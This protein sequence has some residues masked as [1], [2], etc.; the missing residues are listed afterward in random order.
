MAEVKLEQMKPLENSN[1]NR[2]KSGEI[3]KEIK[4]P[5]PKEEQELHI[6]K[7]IAKGTMK[8][9][10]IGTRL[11]EIFV[12]EDIKNVGQYI[13]TEVF[14]PTIKNT[15][16]DIVQNGVS[17]LIF[18]E[19]SSKNDRRRNGQYVS[20]GSY[21]SNT[22]SNSYRGSNRRDSERDRLDNKGDII[23][24]NR[25]DAQA[26][27]SH[28]CDALDIYRSVTVAN[29]YEAADVPSNYQDRKWGWSDLRYANVKMARGGGWY[30]DLPPAEYLD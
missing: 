25:S 2:V 22:R 8:K 5:E 14:I 15:V 4:R 29:Y 27:L 19:T 13:F 18:G 11:K 30:I 24:D 1:S 7:A 12:G 6:D 10:S 26:V 17:L 3:S 9:K 20:Y 23:F 21:S 28:L 16:V